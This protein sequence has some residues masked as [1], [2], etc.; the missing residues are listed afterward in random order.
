ME[1]GTGPTGDRQMIL[2]SNDMTRAEV[3]KVWDE[4]TAD[5]VDAM[6]AANIDPDKPET[7]TQDIIDVIRNWIEAGDECAA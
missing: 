3:L 5:L 1:T 7:K 4:N 2:I 6:I